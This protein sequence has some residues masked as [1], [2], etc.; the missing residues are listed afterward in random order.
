MIKA[1]EGMVNCEGTMPALLG[2]FGTIVVSL[3]D[4]FGYDA[5]NKAYNLALKHGFE[6]ENLN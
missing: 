4:E 2:E 6:T 5:V 1:N 3:I